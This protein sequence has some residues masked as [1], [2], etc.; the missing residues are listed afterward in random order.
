MK[1]K[2]A[3]AIGESIVTMYRI[4]LLIIVVLLIMGIS[5]GIYMPNINVKDSE[6][7]IL[8]KKIT[9]CIRDAEEFNIEKIKKDFNSNILKYCDFKYNTEDE[10]YNKY[11]ISIKLDEETIMFGDD[12]RSWVNEIL[13]TNTKDLGEFKQG[14]SSIENTIIL[15][16][17]KTKLNL[18]VYVNE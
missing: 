10:L 17:K 9:N 8:S 1:N 7:I 14:Y 18:E 5:N 3:E 15:N 6:A 11:F 2:K 13:K 16:D 4:F 12:G